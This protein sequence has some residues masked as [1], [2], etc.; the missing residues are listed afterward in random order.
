M[1]DLRLRPAE[2]ADYSRRCGLA[3]T[4]PQLR[5]L[6]QISE[7][8]FSAV[9]LNLRS[10]EESRR[11]LSGS[12]DIYE[13]MTVTL[14]DTLT[15]PERTFLLR[16][17]PVDEF[18]EPQAAY[19]TELPES[20]AILRRLSS[21]NAFVQRLPD[22]AT[23]RFHHMLKDCA[24]QQFDAL[25]EPERRLSSAAAAPGTRTGAST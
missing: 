20:G 6:D 12:H 25:P 11:L 19:L 7:G 3:L 14:L 5:E 4:E 16:L 22:G 1:R 10:Y 23:Y 2:L 13:M 24:R 8:W 21:R 17:S 15:E 9:Y 18:T